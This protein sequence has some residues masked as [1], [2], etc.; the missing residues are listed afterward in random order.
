MITRRKI[1]LLIFSIV[2]II[3]CLP[4]TH[5]HA[6][7]D[8]THMLIA[9]LTFMELT[10]EQQQEIHVLLKS[11]PHYE[12]FLLKDKPD[13]CPESLWVFMRAAI[14][15]DFVNTDEYR[16]EYHRRPWHFV[17]IP[18]RPNASDSAM[19]DPE[20]PFYSPNILTAL[21]ENSDILSEGYTSNTRKAIAISWLL[22]LFGDVHQPLHCINLYSDRFPNGD[23]GGSR[24]AVRDGEKLTKLHSFWDNILG[25]EKGL[26]SIRNSALEIINENVIRDNGDRCKWSTWAKQSHDLALKHVYLEGEQP[27]VEWQ[28]EFQS[29]SV[30]DHVP[31]ITENYRKEGVAV[32]KR[33]VFLA[34]RRL[35]LH[36][37][38]R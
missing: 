35:A 21:D 11:H 3:F 5:V 36:L 8:R 19:A 16:A 31:N 17:N 29:S 7:N 1:S 18:Y 15:P 24:I 25:E 30:A 32:A 12:I 20:L 10:P 37:A 14:W 6:W 26:S 38:T 9:Y 2:V 4:C 27:L 28:P 34:S 23:Q 22:H 33:Q 13:K